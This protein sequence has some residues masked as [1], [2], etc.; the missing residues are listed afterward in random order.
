MDRM[1][2]RDILR[3]A[4]KCYI[5]D[6]PLRR[7]PCHHIATGSAELC[8]HNHKFTRWI[9]K[10]SI[11]AHKAKGRRSNMYK[12]HGGT[13]IWA[14][15]IVTIPA[16]LCQMALKLEGHD[17]WQRVEGKGPRWVNGGQN[18]KCG[19]SHGQ[20]EKIYDWSGST[21]AAWCW[22]FRMPGMGVRSG[23]GF[24]LYTLS[25]IGS[26]VWL[27]EGSLA[28]GMWSFLLSG[29]LT[30]S[31]SCRLTRF[32]N[33]QTWWKHTQNTKCWREWHGS[34]TEGKARGTKK[35]GGAKLA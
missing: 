28:S 33:L 20:T 34:S 5:P 26:P 12:V 7:V 2:I 13:L 24:S 19:M 27:A 25:G 18:H 8:T 9:Q 6:I 22:G 17:G 4:D 23:S 16:L 3:E 10:Y 32:L 35:R 1:R 21:S 29:L 31:W 30:S 11:H 15:E 14:C